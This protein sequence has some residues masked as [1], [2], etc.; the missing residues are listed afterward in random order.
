MHVLSNCNKF[1]F[2]FEFEV[3]MSVQ[4]YQIFERDWIH[5][6]HLSNKSNLNTDK[7]KIFELDH[8]IYYISWPKY[9]STLQQTRQK[10][11]VC[12][13]TSYQTNQENWLSKPNWNVVQNI[14]KQG[15]ELA[16]ASRCLFLLCFGISTENLVV[17]QLTLFL[18]HQTLNSQFLLPPFHL[19]LITHLIIMASCL[20]FVYISLCASLN[21]SVLNWTQCQLFCY[22]S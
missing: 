10:A 16:K 1:Y 14:N 2:T 13:N 8:D 5:I 22:S 19:L 17:N 20:H 7:P 12:S 9:L 18:G 21:K 3:G 4:I 6:C 11:E 15:H